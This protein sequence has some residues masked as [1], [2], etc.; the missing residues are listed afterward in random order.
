ME[1]SSKAERKREAQ[2][3][4]EAANVEYRCGYRRRWRKENPEKTRIY[5][6]RNYE[7]HKEKWATYCKQWR[8]KNPE[9]ARGIWERYKER[10][11]DR[12]RAARLR[13]RK[14]PAY[15]Y[16][17]IKQNSMKKGRPFF[18]QKDEFIKWYNDQNKVCF[19]CGVPEGIIPENF[20]QSWGKKKVT[21]RLTIDRVDN[22]IGYV[23]NNLVLACPKCNGVK[24]DF[25]T[26]D[27]MKF[28]GQ[29]VMKQ[30]WQ[31]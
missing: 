8:L 19:Y 15:F 31:K 10:H 21:D 1:D 9:K 3:R 28:I 18:L 29:E 17:S 20:K 6:K 5:S 12:I 14:T 7:R 16:E 22:N 24:G 23:L 30:K 13:Y 11:P 26:A 25:F 4:W 27:E 2:K